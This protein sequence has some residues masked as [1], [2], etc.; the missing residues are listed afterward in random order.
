ML[1]EQFQ[2]GG[3]KDNRKSW[4]GKV[5]KQ[6]KKMQGSTPGPLLTYPEGGSIGILYNQV[7]KTV[8]PNLLKFKEHL[9]INSKSYHF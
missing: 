4:K 2:Q 6:W 9:K 8:F 5:S 7:S 3:E 1:S